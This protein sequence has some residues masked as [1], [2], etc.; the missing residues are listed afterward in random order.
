MIEVTSAAEKLR[1]LVKDLASETDVAVMPPRLARF[2]DAMRPAVVEEIA[3]LLDAAS[4][5][6][7]LPHLWHSRYTKLA[8]MLHAEHGGDAYKVE[9]EQ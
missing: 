2:L 4:M 9:T 1:V 8:D 7:Q 6:D 5:S 3:A